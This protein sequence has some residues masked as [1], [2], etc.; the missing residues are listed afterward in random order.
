L[1]KRARCYPGCAS[2]QI[3][4]GA[5][6][7][8]RSPIDGAPIAELRRHHQTELDAMIGATEGAFAAWPPYRERRS[9]RLARRDSLSHSSFSLY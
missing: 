2:R 4:L 1:L 7:A 5:E 9:M 6:L 3:G 8:V